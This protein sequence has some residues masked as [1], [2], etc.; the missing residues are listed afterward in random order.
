MGRSRAG[1]ATLTR[2]R[3]L[4]AGV[5]PRGAVLLAALTFAS[6]VM[7]LVRDRVFARTFGAGSDLD[8]YNAALVLPELILDVLVIAGLSAA[9]VPVF[10]RLR[11]GEDG[12]VDD[13]RTDDFARTVLTVSVLLMA[14]VVAV[15]F[16]LAPLT[17]ELVAHGFDPQQRE[18]YT[19]LSQASTFD[20]RAHLGQE[21]R[22]ETGAH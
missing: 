2:I 5:V 7:G 14:A 8:V 17:V 10:A 19:Q 16:V 21:A 18:L 13:R 20:P 4:I 12:E 22:N 9:F 15:L 1:N 11:R 3:D 6:Y